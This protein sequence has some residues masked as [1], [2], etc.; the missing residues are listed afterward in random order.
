MLGRPD[1]IGLSVTSLEEDVSPDDRRV[2]AVRCPCW[3]ELRIH[4]PVFKT[5]SCLV[6]SPLCKVSQCEDLCTLFVLDA[7]FRLLSHS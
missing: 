1:Q 2:A 4:T 7:Q 6:L 5:W 3:G